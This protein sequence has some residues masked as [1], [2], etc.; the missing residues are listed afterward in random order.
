LKIR[1]VVVVVSLLTAIPLLAQQVRTVEVTGFTG[2]PQLRNEW[3]WAACIQSL[4]TSKGLSIGQAEI[5][6][7][8]YGRDVNRPAP[9]FDGTVALLNGLR[10]TSAGEEWTVH[11]D[12]RAGRPDPRRIFAALTGNEP[13]MVW[14]RVPD[15]DHA[16]VLTGG[17]YLTDSLGN[18][19]G[20]RSL[21]GFDP[22]FNRTLPIPAAN[23]PRFVYGTF[24]ITVS[25]SPR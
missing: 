7:A 20:W 17:K 13:V 8:A 24:S 25:K 23:V 15:L 6:E 19:T 1:G 11:A 12:A 3:C 5:V 16:I 10:L 14:F 22:M 4:L 21:T 9:G 2:H 18:F